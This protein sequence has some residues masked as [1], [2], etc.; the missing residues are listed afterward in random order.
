[1]ADGRPIFSKQ[2]VGR[3]AEPEEIINLIKKHGQPGPG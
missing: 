3:F 2:M 1:M